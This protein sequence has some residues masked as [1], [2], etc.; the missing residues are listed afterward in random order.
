MPP[1]PTAGRGAYRLLTSALDLDTQLSLAAYRAPLA[2]LRLRRRS[3]AWLGLYVLAA[4]VILAIVARLIVGHRGDF[5]SAA[6]SYVLPSEWHAA[7]KTV[8]DRFF[9]AQT[10]AV[11]TNA[12]VSLSLVVV[13]I[14][15][16]PLKE[17]VSA[18]FEEDLA[19]TTDPVK[20]HPLWFQ[21][22]EELQLMIVMLALQATI[23][24]IGYSDQA[25]RGTLA[26][27]LSYIVLF[28]SV[29][30][31]FLTPVL[32]RHY[33]RY[34]QS[35]VTLLRHPLLLFLFGALFSLPAIGATT[36][37]TAH[38]E[39]QFSTQLAVS[40]G[41][42]IIGVTLAVLGGTIAGAPLIE[43]AQARRVPPLL[44][45]ALGYLAVVALIAWNAQRYGAV[46]RSLHHKSQILKCEY[47][48]DWS[49]FSADVPSTM[50]LIAAARTGQLTVAARFSVSVHN[51]TSVDV[52]IEDNR[53]ELRQKSQLVATTSLPRGKVPAGSTQKLDLSLPLTI[54]ANQVMRIRELIT[55]EGWTLTLYLH[56]ADNFDFPVFLVSA[57]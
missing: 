33:T 57:P 3:A 5:L 41:G 28:A 29:G 20:E 56:V 44:V 4:A 10:Q 21:G 31:D 49:S 36:L 18:V 19:L 27:V 40:F 12:A 51:P 42:Q 45:R 52:E 53:L 55:T 2:S 30:I 47:T 25:W 9:A 13:T 39:W 32:Q 17:H 6:L 26:T 50:E 14:S 38:P 8:I 48:V 22:L 46:G 7:A 37:A 24:W 16:F 43:H 1:L 23:F 15:L 35:L 11:I 34:S 54:N